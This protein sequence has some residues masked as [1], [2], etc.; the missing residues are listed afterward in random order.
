MIIDYFSL[1]SDRIKKAGSGEELKR[2]MKAYK[3]RLKILQHER[4]IHLLVTMIVAVIGMMI[5]SL[6]LIT[7]IFILYIL[8][9]ILLI[10]FG[11]Y[12]FHYYKLEN[13][14]QKF[15]SLA[16]DLFR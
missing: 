6:S 1:F 13:T 8:S 4:L 3:L 11:A 14:T 2:V 16:D 15:E 12:I 7:N 9:L 10:L 5:F